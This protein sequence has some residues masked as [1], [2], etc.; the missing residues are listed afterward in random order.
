MKRLRDILYVALLLCCTL[1]CSTTS[2]IPADEVLYTGIESVI[3][4]PSDTVDPAIDEAMLLTLEV[5][6]TNSF[7]GSAYH[8][9][10]LPVG[11]WAY[12]ALYPKKDTGFRHWLWNRLKSEPKYISTV[13]PRLRA[14]AVEAILKDEGYFDA[15]VSYDTIYNKEDSL[16]ARLSYDVTYHKQ[17]CLGSISYRQSPS[18]AV[19]SLLQRTRSKSLLQP[20]LR[21]SASRLEEEKN[22][23]ASVMHDS[24]YFFFSPDHVKYLGDST[25]APN[26][27]SLRIVPDVNGDIK[28]LR[29]CVI[30]SVFYHLD[31]G[32]G[33]KLQNHDSLG[34]MSVGYNGQQTVKSKYLQRAI[35]FEKGALYHPS[36]A[37]KVKQ[38]LNR[39]SAFQYTTTEYQILNP[40]RYQEAMS[41]DPALD[42]LHLMLKV[43]AVN[44]MPWNGGTEIGVVYKDNEQVGPGYTLTAQR[45]NLFGGGEVFTGEITGSY[46]WFIGKR[47]KQGSMPNSFELGT[48]L[49]YTIPRLP[50]SRLWH[51]NPYNPVS[52]KYSISADWQR[53]GGFFEMVK[54]SGAME[55]SF[56][57]GKKHSFTFTP[58]RLTY[59][60]KVSTTAR[61]DSIVNRSIALE[62]SL[63]DQF[64]P[65]MMFSWTYDNASTRQNKRSQ[66][67]LRLT[68]AE[69]GGLVDLFAGW[70]GKH[71]KQGERQLWNQRFSQFVKFTGEFRNTYHISP[72][73]SLVFRALAGVGYTYGNSASDEMPYSEQFYI[74]G[75]NSLRGF[76]ARTVGPGSVKLSFLEDFIDIGNI[77]LFCVGDYKLETNVEYRFP[78]FG[79][80]NGA[81]FVDAGN[82][83][84]FKTIDKEEEDSE[85][86]QIFKD[87]VCDYMKG[88][89]L[90]QLAVDCGAG[91]RL[92]LGM[93]VVRFD[94]GVPLHDPNQMGDHYF[95][96]REGFFKQLGYNLAVGYPF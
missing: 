13:N 26:T 20:G 64:I 42:T 57:R 38:N 50:F 51:A 68:I 58:L 23:I 76:A 10:P 80:L 15:I 28:A 86:Y 7:F 35:G 67:Y 85:L 84:N 37:D 59:M 77:R 47:G 33:M 48:K 72:K 14:Q 16:Q 32:Y 66:Q 40:E 6:P 71:K 18:I 41:L 87:Y 2:H 44:S 94:V 83:W 52:S 89:P 29:P 90:K 43:H 45:R 54:T 17:S 78:L 74:G 46:E 75:A 93:L 31:Y 11:L 9:S 70:W 95:N 62:N 5:P 24:G 34:F 25:F 81:F 82:I 21:F 36:Y 1:S 39:L 61:F 12:N 63:E 65:Q 22:R 73:Q 69:A 27:V 53:R 96:C 92:D 88:N 49:S 60:Q 56:S 19:D 8:L 4:H 91:L 30:D 79:S 55:Y 3:R